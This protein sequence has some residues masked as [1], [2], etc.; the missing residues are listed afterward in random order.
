MIEAIKSRLWRLLQEKEVS[1]A[2]LLDTRGAILWHRGRPVSGRTLEEGHGFPKSA[3]REAI[4]RRA[5]FQEDDVVVESSGEGLPQ[6]ARVLYVR[7]LVILPVD[8]TL[9]LYVDSGSRSSF[10][11]ADREVLTLLGEM[12]RDTLTSI[13]KDEM[14]PGG[15]TGPSEAMDR[16]RELVVRYSLEEDPVL[17]L[18]ETGVGKSHVA[19][20]LHRYSGLAGKLVVVNVPSIPESLFE[21]ELFGH[22]RGAYTGAGDRSLGLVHEAENGTLFLDEVS[23]VPTAVQAK[24]LAFV[25]TRRYRVLG[26]SQEREARVRIVAASNRD[27]AAE[28]KEKRFRS[29]LFYRLNVLPIALPPLR[30]RPEDLRALVSHHSGLLRG[31]ELGDGFWTVVL[32][33]SWPG[34]V[35]EL[36]HVLK[37]A[38]ISLPGPAIGSE[39][40]ELLATDEASP[41]AGPMGAVARVE[42]AIRAGAS[43]W[44]TAWRSFLDREINREELR[45][46][47]ARA[48]AENGSSLRRLARALH[49]ADEDYPRFVSSLHKYDVHPARR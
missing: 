37:R 24:L 4:R 3:I 34:N 41:A 49:V 48:F 18:G 8:D 6:S 31:K 10:S 16:V 44:E 15:I 42:S 21:S 2:M 11:P 30:Q 40:R 20:L 29:D 43:F 26:E 46:L 19:A 36:I 9:L 38:G 27:L 32:S 23:E 47:L 12:L 39:V 25:E 33:H 45:G 17:L 28:V 5:A 1:L 35:R 13:K 22:A 14:E 7:S